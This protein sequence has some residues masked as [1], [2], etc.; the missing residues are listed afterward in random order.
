MITG[1]S[2]TIGNAIL[3]RATAEG[4]PAQFTI[5]SRS[6]FLQAKMRSVY[7]T[8]RYI[9]GDVRDYTTLKAAIAGH[10]IVIHAAAMKRI[11]ECEQQPIECFKTNVLGSANV[12]RACI[13][14]NVNQCLGISTDKACQPITVYG[15]SKL[16]MERLFQAQPEPHRPPIYPDGSLDYGPKFYETKT[17]DDESERTFIPPPSSLG[18]KFTLIRYGNVIESRGSV[19]PLWLKQQADSKP[20]TITSFDMSRFWITPNQAVNIV[21]GGLDLRHGQIFIPKMAAL[22]LLN[23]AH[24]IVGKSDL[25]EIGLRSTERIHEYLVSPEEMSIDKG[26]HFIIDQNDG[27]PGWQWRSDT[28]PSIGR[29]EFMAMVRGDV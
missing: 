18:T 8:V 17:T 11:P 6:E 10:D 1:G 28:A 7:P 2:G 4:W 23:M 16:M 5:Y 21:L 9:L 15:A 29:A 25:K 19:I 13:E 27:V 22:S 20:I 26:D 24:Y 14:N 12:A 3:K